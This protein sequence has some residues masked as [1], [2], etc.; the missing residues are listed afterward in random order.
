MTAA[1]FEPGRH[2]GAGDADFAGAAALDLVFG[3]RAMTASPSWALGQSRGS[4]CPKPREPRGEPLFCR[5]FAPVSQQP[6]AM[7]PVR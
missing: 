7:L 5:P 4:H 6:T 1:A 2:G 3:V